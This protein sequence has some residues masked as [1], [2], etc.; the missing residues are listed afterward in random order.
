[1]SP[2]FEYL[3][4]FTV[5]A[6]FPQ[7][8]LATWA[9]GKAAQI[10][11]YDGAS[12]STF[13]AHASSWWTGSPFV[14]GTGAKTGADCFPLNMPTDSTG[15]INAMM[16]EESTTSD[17]IEPALA[18]GWCTYWDG[19][20]CTGNELAINFTPAGTQEG[21]C[22][23]GR[24]KDSLLWK[25]AR[26]YIHATTTAASSQAQKL[27]SSSSSTSTIPTTSSASL[28]STSLI[29]DSLSTSSSTILP[30]SS[31]LVSSSHSS[32]IPSSASLPSYSSHLSSISASFASVS[33]PPQSI[34]AAG[35]SLH[36]AMIA[37]VTAGAVSLVVVALLL[38]FCIRRRGQKKPEAVLPYPLMSE[39]RGSETQRRIPPPLVSQKSGRSGTG[40]S[41]SRSTTPGARRRH[42]SLV[43]SELRAL[44]E[45]ME[46]LSSAVTGGDGNEA[47][48]RALERELQSYA[49]AERLDTSLPGYL[50]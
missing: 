18:N 28:S 25:S 27:E 49:D 3:C 44:R 24:S 22:E 42:Q 13:T 29:K 11:F 45:Q 32:P 43:S 9:P 35:E 5:I 33:T 2:L 50:D 48:I 20:Y 41:R 23:A 46:R 10:N 19:F 30:S 21:P 12:C 34:L 37:G 14:G 40:D 17:T 47:R 6:H 38:V 4:I 1:M 36:T 15:I 31:L 8:S 26:C 39:P 7:L 16:W